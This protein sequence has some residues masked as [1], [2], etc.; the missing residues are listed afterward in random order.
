MTRE[1]ILQQAVD[2]VKRLQDRLTDAIMENEC[3]KEEETYVSHPKWAALKRSILD[4]KIVL[5][6][7]TTGKYTEE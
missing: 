4:T 2:E 6:K 1:E 7:I 5:S 3:R